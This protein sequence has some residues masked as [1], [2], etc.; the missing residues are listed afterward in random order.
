MI[1]LSVFDLLWLLLIPST[2]HCMCVSKHKVKFVPKLVLLIVRQYEGTRSHITPILPWMIETKI[3]VLAV[4][5]FCWIHSQATYVCTSTVNSLPAFFFLIFKPRLQLVCTSRVWLS[6]LN[7][8]YNSMHQAWQ[9][10]HASFSL[11]ILLDI[12][13][14]HNCYLIINCIFNCLTA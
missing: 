1:I 12:E 14:N 11:V 5:L 9:S 4:D 6:V 2:V 7:V 13:L 3:W 10:L 8:K